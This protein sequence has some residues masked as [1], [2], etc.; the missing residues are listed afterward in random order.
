[1]NTFHFLQWWLPKLLAND[2]TEDFY[3]LSIIEF[4]SRIIKHEILLSTLT[5]SNLYLFQKSITIYVS[6]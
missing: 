3:V 2:Y 6:Y 1:M 4:H 5:N